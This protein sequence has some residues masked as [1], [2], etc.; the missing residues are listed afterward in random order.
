MNF[1]R[2][3]H[4]AQRHGKFEV[5]TRFA[6]CLEQLRHQPAPPVKRVGESHTDHTKVTSVGATQVIPNANVIKD[7][8]TGVEP[9]QACES[10]IY[11]GGG[12]SNNF[13]IPSYQTSAVSNYFAKYNP[14]YTAAQYNNSRTSRGFPDVS[15]NGANY[16]VAVDGEF[17]L[18]YGTSASSPTFASI[19]TIINEYRAAL[20]KKSVGFVNPTLY[21]HP[22]VLNDITQGN[23][24][25]CGT[26]GFSAVPGWDPGKF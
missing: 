1:Q 9:E 12:F 18:V 11:S 24:P 20:G 22:Q 19:L 5:D 13:A 8:A 10:V 16:V 23:N 15:A 3:A 21:A 17:S 4:Y 6:I 2:R 14:P 7:I 26:N 25:G